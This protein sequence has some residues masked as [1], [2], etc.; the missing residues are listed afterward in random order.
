[1][2]SRC[3]GMVILMKSKLSNPL[4]C[5]CCSAAHSCLTLCNPMDYSMPGF[6]VHHQLPEFAQTMSTELVMPS[7]HLILW[8]PLLLLPSIFPRIRVFS[9]ELA[10]QS[11]GWRIGTSALVLP[12]NILVWFPHC[13][14]DSQESSPAL[15]FESI[16][17]L[18][19]SLLYGLT[20]T[21]GHDYWKKHRFDYKDFCQ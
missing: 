5:C 18:V 6:P 7:H 12:V 8:H 1:M 13:S 3:L 4:C 17:S 2:K 16:D 10:L 15:Q 14:R 21:S 11:G 19:L 9:N 20:L